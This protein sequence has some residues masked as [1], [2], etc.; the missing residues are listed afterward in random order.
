MTTTELNGYLDFPHVG[1]AFGLERES[2]NKKT[3]KLSEE[4][5]YGIIWN[6]QPYQG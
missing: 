5:V 2:I 1:Q 4:T 3:G 6:H